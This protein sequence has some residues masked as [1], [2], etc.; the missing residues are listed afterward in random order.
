MSARWLFLSLL[1]TPVLGASAAP[2][3]EAAALR[4]EGPA[5]GQPA[6]DFTLRRLES[7]ETV[8]LSEVAANRPVVLVFGSYT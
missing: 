6:P 8:T 3:P 7:E 2:P 5:V 1:F 4:G